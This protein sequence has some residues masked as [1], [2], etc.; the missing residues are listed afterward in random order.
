MLCAVRRLTGTIASTHDLSYCYVCSG[1]RCTGE[2]CE[3]GATCVVLNG[4]PRCQ[5][6]PGFVGA[7]CD[8]DTCAYIACANNG[9]CVRGRCHCLPGYTDELCAHRV[10]PCSESSC[11]E[12]GRTDTVTS[13]AGKVDPTEEADRKRAGPV[14]KRQTHVRTLK[15]NIGQYGN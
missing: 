9:T 13:L 15:T 2:P 12:S 3:N 5:C 10:D 8:V 7:Y 6:V 4:S 14:V 11:P 1:C